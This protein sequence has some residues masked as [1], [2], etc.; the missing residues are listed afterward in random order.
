[1]VEPQT[2]P[3]TPFAE[4][5]RRYL[6]AHSKPATR[7][8]H[9][10]ATLNGI[11]ATLATIQ[12]GHVGYLIG[13]IVLS[14]SM[15]VGSHWLIEGNQPLIRVNAFYGALADLRMCW[16]ALTGGVSREYERLGLQP[17]KGAEP[18]SCRSQQAVRAGRR[19][20][21]QAR[22]TVRLQ[23]QGGNAERRRA[24]AGHSCDRMSE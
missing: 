12:F 14:V 11:G 9:Y 19:I 3:K 15:A 10:L 22:G 4:F 6:A 23:C 5:W 7:A 24:C 20:L 18:K 16:L 1:M 8:A 2:G 21:E 17:R 13:G